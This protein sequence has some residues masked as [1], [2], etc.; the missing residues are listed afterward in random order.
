[1]GKLVS[2]TKA[3]EILGVSPKTIR[4]WESEGRGI[5]CVRTVG[6]Q[7]RYDISKLMPQSTNNNNENRKLFI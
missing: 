5:D 3:A 4:R 7:R 2:I 6:G 1:M